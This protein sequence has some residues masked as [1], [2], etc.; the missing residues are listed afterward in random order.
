MRKA[1]RSSVGWTAY[2]PLGDEGGPAILT[3]APTDRTMQLADVGRLWRRGM[4]AVVGAARVE[5]NVLPADVIAG[6][7]RFGA[8][9]VP[10][11]EETW[12]GYEH[13]NVQAGL[14]ALLSEPGVDSELVGL[15]GFH[16]RMFGL[17]DLAGERDPHGVRIGGAARVQLPAGPDGAVLPALRCALYLLTEQD[18]RSVLLLRGPEASSG[19]L[20]VTLQ[21]ASEDQATA[22]ALAARIRELT[23]RHNVFRGQ[24]L[25]FDGEMFGQGDTILTFHR[26]PVLRPE[27]LILPAETLAAVQ[28]QVI[29][30]AQHRRRLLASGQ[31]LKRG[32]LLY[33]PPGVGKTHTVRYLTAA[34]TGTTVI[35]LSGRSL[36][37]IGEACS[38][39][40]ALQPSMLVIEDVDLIAEDRGMHPGRTRCCSSCSTRWTGW[41]RTPTCCSRSRPTGPTC[42]NRRWRPGPAASTRPWN[43][44]CRTAPPGPGSSRSTRGRCRSTPRSWTRFWTAPTV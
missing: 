4:R 38:V 25:S 2:A 40:R 41:P 10:V 30:V 37:L 18:V 5:E 11:V 22:T 20:A 21:V 17:A 8:D 36:H 14:D 13:V 29:G 16:H 1:Y 35:Q 12:S 43:C 15:V 26:R 34:L 3:A 32:L 42:S 6:H 39:A 19:Q 28:R 44:R 33:G 7:L 9:D 27:E 31:H 24:V 23:L